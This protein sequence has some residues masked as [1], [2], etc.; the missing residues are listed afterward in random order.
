MLFAGGDPRLALSF[1]RSP[2]AHESL[3]IFVARRHQGSN[4]A[5]EEK[6]AIVAS[7]DGSGDVG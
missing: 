4:H 5:I 2:G 1:Q 6:V 3:G 7:K